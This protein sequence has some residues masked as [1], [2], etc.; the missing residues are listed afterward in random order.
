[1][2][3]VD[4]VSS[5]QVLPDFPAFIADTFRPLDVAHADRPRVGASLICSSTRSFSV[6]E[7]PAP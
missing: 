5:A 4:T 7:K 3:R 1:M 6:A 2:A